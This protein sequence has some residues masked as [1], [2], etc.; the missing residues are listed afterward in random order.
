M[1]ALKE[2][3]QQVLFQIVDSFVRSGEPVSSGAVAR[4]SGLGVSSATIRNVMG[5]LEQMGL[6]TQP[7][8]SSGRVPTAQ[9]MR[10]YVDALPDG[11]GSA[12]PG[13]LLGAA[14][15]GGE[16]D[17]AARRVGGVLS[18]LVQLTTLVTLPGFERVRLEGVRLTGLAEGWRVL[19]ELELE[20]RRMVHRVV[21]MAQRVVASELSEMQGYLTRLVGGKTLGEVRE[22]VLVELE[23]AKSAYNA[24]LRT[25]LELGKRALEAVEPGLVVEGKLRFFEYAELHADI[26]RLGNM[27]QV[28]EQKERVLELLD[29]LCEA[30]RPSVFMGPE[31][32]GWA[33]GP[34]VSLIVCGYSCGG[35]QSGVL[36]LLGPV[37][38]DY[39]RVIPLVAQAAQTLS[40]AVTGR[41]VVGG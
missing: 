33:F 10:V 26:G 12:W 23:A 34:E 32:D 9:G 27:L 28:L 20:S 24:H 40:E 38:M 6:L 2:R 18:Q 31:L 25:A 13:G 4:M 7:H 22:L 41:A 36:G 14:V 1:T 16:V 37:R 39:A 3:H 21:P 35:G 29:R 5:D 17:D 15:P 30:S 19:V 11:D 8:T